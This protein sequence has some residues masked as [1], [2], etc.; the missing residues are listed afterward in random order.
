MLPGLAL[1]VGQQLEGKVLGPAGNGTTQVAIRG[2]TLALLL[3]VPALAGTTVQFEVLENGPQL[4]LALLTPPP[5]AQAGVR[6]AT[7]PGS[8]QPVPATGTAPSGG[9]PVA[10]PAGPTGVTSVSPS[11]GQLAG[12]LAPMPIPVANA[13]GSGGLNTQ[14]LLQAQA[15]PGMRADGPAPQA[16]P[17]PGSP[18]P[19]GGPASSPPSS[20]AGAPAS[21]QMALATMVRDA[22]AS[23]GSVT[24]LTSALTQVAGRVALPEP[25]L[26]AAQQVLAGRLSLGEGRLDGAALSQAVRRSGVFQEALM[27]RGAAAPKDLKASLLVLR[28]TLT[29]WLGQQAEITAISPVPPP[30]RGSV[31]RARAAEAPP[32]DPKLAAEAVGKQLLDRTEGALSRIRLHQHASLP[33]AVSSKPG[34]EWQ[35]ELPVVIGQ[36]QSLIHLQIQHDEQGDSEGAPEPGWHLRFALNLPELGEVGAQVSL[37]AGSTGVML[38]AGEAATSE[39]L[40][41]NII[42]LRE[43]FAAAGINAATIVVRHGEPSSKRA[44][45][46][47]QM[48]D[49]KR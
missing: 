15:V 22:M 17:L 8:P 30:M 16:V 40:Q 13:G 43:A 38:W 35:L 48:V 19:S 4:R 33:D 20:A 49:A 11:S 37:R 31:P 44:V 23:Q 7:Q 24:A 2:Q 12:A 18:Y 3:P 25:V 6:L 36:H 26:R 5:E 39:A 21:P 10:V 29:N 46:S 32:L 27:A 42:E 1:H 28:S 34:A 41:E 45:P 47:G 14:T 9:A